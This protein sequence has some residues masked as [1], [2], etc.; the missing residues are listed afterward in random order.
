MRKLFSIIYVIAFFTNLCLGQSK[1]NKSLKYLNEK[2]P[3]ITPKVFAP[4]IISTTEG[5]EFGSVFSKKADKF[6][7]AVRLDE[8]WNAEILYTELKSGKWT[9]PE[10]LFPNDTFS[11]NDPFLSFDEKRLYFMSDKKTKENIGKSDLWYIENKDNKWSELINLEKPIN[12]ITNEF[13]ISITKNGTIYFSTNIHSSDIK[14]WD[15]DIYKS[16]IVNN[17]YTKPVRLSKLINSEYFEVDAFVSPDETYMIFCSTREEGYGEGD[18]YISFMKKDN[19]W[20]KAVNMGETI[21]S[22]SHEFCP[23]V[24][25]DGKYLFYTSKGD[26]YWVSSKII[27]NLRK[28]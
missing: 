14:G 4:D 1:T 12:S 21:N 24:S 5:Y 17:K 6:Y 23:F 8:E 7:Y 28:K 16:E 20:S 9:K 15:Y 26:I 13:Y 3:G 27:Q 19:T 2:P 11:C 22:E 10:K 18:L 25:R